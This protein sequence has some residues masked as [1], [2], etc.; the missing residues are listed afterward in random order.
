M[1]LQD[2]LYMEGVAYLVELLTQRGLYTKVSL[3][4]SLFAYFAS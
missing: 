4:V 2:E 1:H 3:L